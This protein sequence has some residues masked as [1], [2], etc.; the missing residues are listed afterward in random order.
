VSKRHD[1]RGKRKQEKGTHS[2]SPTVL[3]LYS[4][5]MALPSLPPKNRICIDRQQRAGLSDMHRVATHIGKVHVTEKCRG[6]SGSQNGLVV[7]LLPSRAELSRQ[8]RFIAAKT[9]TPDLGQSLVVCDALIRSFTSSHRHSSRRR[10][11]YRRA[12]V[13]QS[14]PHFCSHLRHDLRT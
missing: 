13:V 10:R 11:T 6:R 4:V 1:A 2:M 5:E 9:N 3:A 8:R 14:L 12:G 7:R